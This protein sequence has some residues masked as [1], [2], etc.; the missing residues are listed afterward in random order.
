M[1]AGKGHKLLG[2]LQFSETGMADPV[3]KLE[4]GPQ[5]WS[6]GIGRFREMQFV[7]SLLPAAYEG[8]GELFVRVR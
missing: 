1:P 4:E 6:G 3:L 2:L 8:W 5:Y 7:S